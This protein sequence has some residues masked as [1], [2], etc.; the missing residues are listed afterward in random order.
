MNK[1]RLKEIID[2]VKE[3]KILTDR[4]PENIRKTLEE[5]G[6]TFIKIGQI[7]STRVDLLGEEYISELS[8]LRNNIEPLDFNII[9]EILNDTYGNYK[10]IFSYVEETPIGSASIA[11]VHKAKLINGKEVVLKI[12][13]PNIGEEMKQDFE[14]FKEC[15]N[16]L[17][18]NSIIKVIDLELLVDEIYKTT[19]EELD[20]I[21]EKENIIEFSN[22]NK[23]NVIINAPFVIEKLSRDN[24]LVMKY[25]IGVPINEIEKLTNLGFNLKTIAKELSSNYVKQ[26][27]TDGMFHADPHPDNILVNKDTIVYIDWGMVGRLSNKNK[28]LLNECAMAILTEDYDTVSDILIKMSTHTKEIDKE[29]LVNDVTNILDKYSNCN[30]ENISISEFA[31]EMFNLLRNNYLILNYDITMLIRGIGIIESVIKKL[32]SSINLIK[33]FESSLISNE[34]MIDLEKYKKIGRKI[35]KSTN[36]LVD[37]PIETEK[38]IKKINNEELKLKFE[39]SD[40][41]KHVDKIENLIHEI[42]LG[43]IDG[44]LIVGFSIVEIQDMK[45]IFLIAIIIISVMLGIMML[46][47][48]IHHGY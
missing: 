39:L 11:E 34:K 33:V 4:S 5:L 43:F 44:C 42:V 1:S 20:F 47:D 37:I 17:H 6:P 27:L 23:D 7:L 32:D 31:K 26:A 14:L 38:I 15:I 16:L 28:E 2:I 22:N 12:K 8:K 24:I 40:S 10:T 46:L 30:L 45:I 36:S 19:L 9:K 3:N 41:K 13:R 48:L 18:L 35:A 29:R 25:V 21:K